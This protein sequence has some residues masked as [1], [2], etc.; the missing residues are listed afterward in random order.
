MTDNYFLPGEVWRGAYAGTVCAIT[1]E[2]DGGLLA[3]SWVATRWQY[4]P[5]QGAVF[6]A[7]FLAERAH[8]EA[9]EA[10]LAPVQEA[11]RAYAT[12]VAAASDPYDWE[13]SVA[14]GMEVVRR[15]A[16]LLRA[17]LATVEPR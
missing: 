1:R 9:A 13:A 3:W 17:A 10:K 14:A 4:E 11:A 2:R 5:S 7:A 6:A 8:A 15:R 16:A 12:A